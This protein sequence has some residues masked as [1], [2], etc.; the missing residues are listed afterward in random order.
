V[1]TFDPPLGYGTDYIINDVDFGKSITLEL[2][3]EKSWRTKAGPLFVKELDTGAGVTAI[4]LHALGVKVATVVSDESERFCTDTCEFSKNGYCEDLDW[5][6]W[7]T[8][9]TDCGPRDAMTSAPTPPPTVFVKCEDS[10]VYAMDEICDD[11]RPDAFSSECATG[12]DCTDCGP[13]PEGGFEAEAMCTNGVD[14]T[15]TIPGIPCH[16]PFVFQGK[17]YHDCTSDVENVFGWGW[18]STT[19]D[20]DKDNMWG[21]CGYCRDVTMDDFYHDDYSEEDY[22]SSDDGEAME[23]NDEYLELFTDP[24]TPRKSNAVPLRGD[25][26]KKYLE[27]QAAQAA[28]E[29]NR[30]FIIKALQAIA[31]MA[32]FVAGCAACVMAFRR[33]QSGRNLR[34]N[35]ASVPGSLELP[36]FEIR[37]DPPPTTK[38][39]I[40]PDVTRMGD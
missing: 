34:G 10:C 31:A 36:G 29:D 28:S 37:G 22:S 6:D 14:G 20:R 16:F 32:A 11:G 39:P 19:P 27:H 26:L 18:C 8:D 12:T 15:E 2:L 23:N 1:L 17:T 25:A 3:S 40:T 38:M 33:F 21:T 9:C 35:Y 4:G 5:C 13:V 24:P 30:S 7:G